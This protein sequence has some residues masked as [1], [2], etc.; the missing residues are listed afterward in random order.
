MT[1]LATDRDT[2]AKDA[3]LIGYPVATNTVIW[4]GGLVMV[5]D[6]G[7]LIPAADAANGRVVGVADETCNNNPGADGAKK[8]RVRSGKTF[9]FNATSITQAMVGDAMY[10]VDDNTFDDAVGTNAVKCGRLTQFVD[11]THGW[12]FIPDGA[13]RKA[14]VSDGTYSA[15]EQAM[16]DDTIS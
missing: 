2:R 4:K 6:A 16:L 5:N 11:T 1:A 8:C 9:L 15:N 10:V 12:I 3:G 14:G 7:Y 13:L